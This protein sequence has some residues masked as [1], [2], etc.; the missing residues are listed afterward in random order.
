MRQDSRSHYS[1]A[2]G[3]TLAYAEGFYRAGRGRRNEVLNSKARDGLLGMIPRWRPGKFQSSRPAFYVEL[4][5]PSFPESRG[6]ALGL[7]CGSEIRRCFW[8]LVERRWWRLL[9]ETGWLGV[10][11]WGGRLRCRTSGRRARFFGGKSSGVT[12]EASGFGFAIA[13]FTFGE[14]SVKETIAETGDGRADARDFGDVDAGA[15]DHLCIVDR[16]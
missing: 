14:D 12:F 5:L 11:L 15:Y 3:T 13:D 10:G 8:R 2:G 16:S 6:P 4:F 9:R 7:Q 1:A